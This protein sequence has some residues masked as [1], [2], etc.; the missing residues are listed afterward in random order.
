MTDFKSSKYK[1][2]QLQIIF[3]EHFIL[4][5]LSF[6]GVL[7]FILFVFGKSEARVSSRGNN[8]FQ[9][10]SY[11]LENEWAYFGVCLAGAIVFNIAYFLV[12]LKK[13]SIYRLFFDDSKQQLTL[14]YKKRY[15]NKMKSLQLEYANLDCFVGYK[16]SINSFNKVKTLK[17]LYNDKEI[18]EIH[19]SEY[20][21]DKDKKVIDQVYHR[22]KQLKMIQL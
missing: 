3:I 1:T 17:L 4:T 16:D 9:P 14:E 21:W 20:L 12:K 11:F 15:S 22:I 7:L 19:S 10:L 6:L 5:I 18:A 8:H 2:N 13:S